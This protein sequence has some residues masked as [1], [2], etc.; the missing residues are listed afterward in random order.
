MCR[1]EDGEESDLRELK[2][3]IWRQKANNGEEKA[4]VVTETKVCK[5]CRAR[6]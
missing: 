1:L 4:T 3:N 5:D 2:V 6:E